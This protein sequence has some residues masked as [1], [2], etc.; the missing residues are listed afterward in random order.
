MS[1][2]T[3]N[4]IAA[5]FFAMTLLLAFAPS[6]ALAK[7]A[8]TDGLWATIQKGTDAIVKNDRAAFTALLADEVTAAAGSG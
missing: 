3:G 5:G 6:V 1:R 8:A 7:D 2:V 4:R